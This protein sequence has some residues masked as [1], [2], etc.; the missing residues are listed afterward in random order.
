MYTLR[1]AVAAD[2]EFLYHL[3]VATMRPYIE[4]TWGWVETWQRE[5]FE[6]KWEP[7]RNRIIQVNGIDAGVLVTEWHPDEFYLA[8]I[9]ILPVY[10]GRGVGTAVIHDLI[11]QAA[12]QHLPLSLHVLK[13]N[14]PARHLYERLGFH[15]V[16]EEDVRYKMMR[17]T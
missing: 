11:Q 16:A 7:T 1:Q 14:T 2:Y 13:S 17:M 15:I 5:H 3:H 10:Q 9:E 6:R 12:E 8:L 4:A